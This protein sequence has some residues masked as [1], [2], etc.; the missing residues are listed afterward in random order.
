MAAT[1]KRSDEME[2]IQSE[3][4]AEW[5]YGQALPERMERGP[6]DRSTLP[7]QP[8]RSGVAARAP[9]ANQDTVRRFSGLPQNATGHILE[10]H[11]LPSRVNQTATN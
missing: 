5:P 7:C 4:V 6:V 8:R 1:L 3:L 10:K 2:T 11:G 9:K